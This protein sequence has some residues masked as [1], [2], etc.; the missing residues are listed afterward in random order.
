[1]GDLCRGLHADA[2]PA[3]PGLEV[4]SQAPS[5][6]TQVLD[7]NS[8]ADEFLAFQHNTAGSS[9]LEGQFVD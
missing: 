5:A 1:M 4:P 8:H 3:A 2:P 6:Q 9:S 7:W